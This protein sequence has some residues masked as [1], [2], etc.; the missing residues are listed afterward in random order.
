MPFLEETI[1][2]LEEAD[3]G[4]AFEDIFAGSDAKLPETQATVV[5]VRETGGFGGIRTHDVSSVAYEEPTGMVV[6]RARTVKDARNKARAAY[7]AL[8]VSN[9]YIKGTWYLEIVPT[10]PP[11]EM[12]KSVSGLPRYG[13]NFR[14]LKV[15]S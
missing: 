2:L 13:F 7:D 9:R 3:V 15:P 12:A 5:T 10:Q 6:A 1:G 14:A 11:F 4:R 8:W